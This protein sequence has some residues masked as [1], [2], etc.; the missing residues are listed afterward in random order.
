MMNN[1]DGLDEGKAGII[2][3][4]PSGQDHSFRGFRKVID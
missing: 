3:L 4:Y 2:H 1:N